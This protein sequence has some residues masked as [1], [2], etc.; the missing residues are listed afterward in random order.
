MCI[1]FLKRSVSMCL[2]YLC[3]YKNITALRVIKVSLNEAK[4]RTD[5]VDNK[6]GSLYKIYIFIVE[7][8]EVG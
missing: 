4:G 8:Q 6:D 2:S 5:D 7:K 1:P 3:A